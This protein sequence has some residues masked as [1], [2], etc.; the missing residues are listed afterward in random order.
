M[1]TVNDDGK[2]DNVLDIVENV[3]TSCNAIIY[4]DTETNQYR[5]R[6]IKSDLAGTDWTMDKDDILEPDLISRISYEDT[7]SIVRMN[8]DVTEGTAYVN[9]VN[10]FRES[11]FSRAFNNESRSKTL[12]HF[13]YDSSAVIDFKSETFNN[14][15]VTYTWSVMSDNF[16]QIDIGDIVEIDNVDGRLLAIGESVRLVIVSRTRSVEKIKLVG[17]EFSKIP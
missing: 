9:N 14:P 5:Y 1:F 12:N 6:I 11:S 4:L 7:A 17:Y 2:L 16:F 3:A 15:Q 13:L 8:N 10:T